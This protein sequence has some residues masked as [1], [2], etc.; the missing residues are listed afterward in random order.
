MTNVSQHMASSHPIRCRRINEVV[1]RSVKFEEMVGFYQEVVG[2]RLLRRFEDVVAFLQVGTQTGEFIS[3]VT[4]FAASR[5]SNFQ[6]LP[7]TG[8]SPRTTTL[9]HFALNIASGDVDTARSYLRSLGIEY[10]TAV[11]TWIGW[12]STFFLDP[13]GNT[14]ELV[15]YNSTLDRGADYDYSRLYGDPLG[16]R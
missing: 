7:F 15:C 10:S 16:E 2:L 3:T 1:L 5:L 8:L 9:H 4:I 14:V 6:D 11:H 13:D 12:G